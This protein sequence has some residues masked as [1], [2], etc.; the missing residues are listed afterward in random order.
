MS[1]SNTLHKLK[2][3]GITAKKKYGQ[4]FIFDENILSKIVQK[5]KINDKINI[6]EIGP[7]PG[8]LTQ[9]ILKANVDQVY[10][11]EK[12]K[13]FSPILNDIKKIFPNRLHIFYDR[14]WDD[15]DWNY[16]CHHSAW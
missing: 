6:L 7:G 13:D 11:V 4:N 2:L 5:S 1:S 15:S 10:V 3:Y 9:E 12:D 16:V 14:S 8:G